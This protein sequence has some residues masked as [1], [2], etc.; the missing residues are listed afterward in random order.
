MWKTKRKRNFVGIFLV[1]TLSEPCRDLVNVFPCKSQGK[2]GPCWHLV[3]TLSGKT[4]GNWTL[5]GL[6]RNLV[7]TLSPFP[8]VNRKLEPC[9]NLVRNF[10]VGKVCRNLCWNLVGAL[11]RDLVGIYRDL[12][13]NRRESWDLV[14]TLSEPC[15]GHY[16][17]KS[18]RN[19]KLVGTSSRPCWGLVM[20]FPGSCWGTL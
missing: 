20:V 11:S 14:G 3:G 13:T 16:R 18:Q 15:R 6:C 4:K 10:A 5:L 17:P 9:G 2:L 12:V 1:G 19:W 7:G 8:L